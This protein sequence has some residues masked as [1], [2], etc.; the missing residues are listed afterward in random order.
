MIKIIDPGQVGVKTLFGKVEDTPIYSGLN[1]VNPLVEVTEYNVKTRAYTMS[2]VADEGAKPGDDAIEILTSDGL[3]VKID[4]TVLYSLIPSKTPF[5]RSTIGNDID[6]ETNIVRPETR[7][8]IRNNAVYFDAVSLFSTKRA[9]FQ[10]RIVKDLNEIFASRGIHLEKVLIRNIT[11]PE[12]VSKSIESKIN[13]EQDAQK[14]QFVLQKERQEADRKRVEAQGIA[15]YQKIISSG[16]NDK[17]LQYE[18]IKVQKELVTSPNSKII[19]M[20]NSRNPMILS[21]K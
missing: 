20:G 9:E 5:I 18:G 4:L 2:K 7:T 6:L 15:D 17:M 10:N 11:L 12:T 8:S 3:G 13:A 14:M 19:I 16:L 1:I 21:D